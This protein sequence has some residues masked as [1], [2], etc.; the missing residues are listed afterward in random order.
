M[1]GGANDLD[2][3]DTVIN[4]NLTPNWL[5]FQARDLVQQRMGGFLPWALKTFPNAKFV[6]TGY[7]SGVSTM[8]SPAGLTPLVL[9]MAA[10]Y[11]ELGL[12]FP[13]PALVGGILAA[14][15]V[16]DTIGRSAAFEKGTSDGLRAAIAGSGGRA[17]FVSPDFQPAHAY[18]APQTLMFRF[19]E[20]D[21]VAA[22]RENECHTI[23]APKTGAGSSGAGAVPWSPEGF[24]RKAATFH[25][26]P[27]GARRY[28]DRII[29]ALPG[30]MPMVNVASRS[31]RLTVQ[32]TTAS[33]T[34]TVTVTAVDGANGQPVQGTVSINGVSGATGTP[35]TFK[36]CAEAVEAV[37]ASAGGKPVRRPLAR[38]G[39]AVAC[40]GSVSAPGYPAAIFEY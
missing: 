29:A 8:S 24:C 30:I 2:F 3:V 31:L 12:A 40:K 10:I 38:G 13:V 22:G 20:R 11:A 35:V 5:E 27:A 18:G 9:G 15:F 1:D 21:P 14:G 19:E 25:P 17:V 36:P 23:Y 32:G 34:K 4:A 7:Y 37:D 16:A 26:N 33:T 28:A 6:V 39:A